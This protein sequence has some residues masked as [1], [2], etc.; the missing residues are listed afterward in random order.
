[1]SVHAYDANTRLHRVPKC[2]AFSRSSIRYAPPSGGSSI[3]LLRSPGAYTLG[4]CRPPPPPPRQAR[5]QRCLLSRVPVQCVACLAPI[6]RAITPRAAGRPAASEPTMYPRSRGACGM[7]LASAR[8]RPSPRD[9]ADV[10]HRQ[11]VHHLKARDVAHEVAN[12][13]P[14]IVVRQRVRCDGRREGN[15]GRS[16]PSR[17]C[18][19]GARPLDQ[20]SVPRAGALRP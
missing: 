7:L 13:V 6:R 16:S 2:T 9:V 8:A 20:P 5:S 10:P 17:D 11:H 3:L 14:P 1:M 4:C 19:G 18:E 15:K 12:V